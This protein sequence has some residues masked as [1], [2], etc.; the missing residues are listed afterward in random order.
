MAVGGG[1][2]SVGNATG[3]TQLVLQMLTEV[4]TRLSH[5]IM[6]RIDEMGNRIDDVEESFA[7]LVHE[8]QQDFDQAAR[9]V[10]AGSG[11]MRNS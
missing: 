8:P 10:E 3:L 1:A 7:D 6:N 2:D 11:Q 4:H 9:N 5:N